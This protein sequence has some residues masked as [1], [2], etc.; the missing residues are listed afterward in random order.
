MV[1][2]LWKAYLPRLFLWIVEGML[3]LIC[4]LLIPISGLT[5]FLYGRDNFNWY[6]GLV[7]AMLLA[8]FGYQVANLISFQVEKVFKGKY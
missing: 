5:G 8:R 4:L 6:I 1:N 7:F 2:P 3:Y